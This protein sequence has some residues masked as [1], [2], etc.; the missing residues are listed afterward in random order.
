MFVPSQGSVTVNPTVHTED[1]E[2]RSTHRTS[3]NPRTY[4]AP[5]FLAMNTGKCREF[6]KNPREKLC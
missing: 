5:C 4:T 6:H 3:G 2:Q 1:N